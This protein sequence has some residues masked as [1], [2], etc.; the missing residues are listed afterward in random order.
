VATRAGG[1]DVEQGLPYARVCQLFDRG[2]G[3]ACV[4]RHAQIGEGV[5]RMP[6]LRALQ[7]RAQS[8]RFM[9]A[10]TGGCIRAALRANDGNLT[11]KRAQAEQYE[12]KAHHSGWA[13]HLPCRCY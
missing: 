9:A 12:Q 7:D 6:G 3:V 4:A 10:Y 11:G 13:S 2:L 5:V 1:A 8:L